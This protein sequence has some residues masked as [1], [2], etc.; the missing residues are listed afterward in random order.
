MVIHDMCF[1]SDQIANECL[2]LIIDKFNTDGYVSLWDIY[3]LCFASNERVTIDHEFGWDKATDVKDLCVKRGSDNLY[4]IIYP[5][6]NPRPLHIWRQPYRRDT[7]RD[8][9]IMGQQGLSWLMRNYKLN[10]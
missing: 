3:G 1:R 7:S 2:N 4:H 9:A 8:G 5:K 10:R 6:T